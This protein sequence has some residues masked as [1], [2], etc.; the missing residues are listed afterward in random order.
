[1]TGFRGNTPNTNTIADYMSQLPML[2]KRLKNV[3]GM[4]DDKRAIAQQ[5]FLELVLF[6][7]HYNS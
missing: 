7:G 2:Q 3:R 5:G 6:H 4:Q 1:M